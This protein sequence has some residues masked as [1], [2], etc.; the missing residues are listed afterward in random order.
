MKKHIYLAS[1]IIVQ[2]EYYR[3][4]SSI[5]TNYEQIYFR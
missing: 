4:D 3:P 2:L 5:P 1:G